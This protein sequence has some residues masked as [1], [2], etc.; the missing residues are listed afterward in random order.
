MELHKVSHC[1]NLLLVI[2]SNCLISYDND[3]NRP[4]TFRVPD[5]TDIEEISSEEDNGFEHARHVLHENNF[6]PR[7]WSTTGQIDLT[8]VDYE[9][10]KSGLPGIRDQDKLP[11]DSMYGML[12]RPGKEPE[13]L[14][15]DEVSHEPLIQKHPNVDVP[16]AYEDDGIHDSIG[17]SPLDESID[18]NDSEEE[19]LSERSE[20]AVSEA[21][22]DE[23]DDLD[24]ESSFFVR[25]EYVDNGD[26]EEY[27]D[28]GGEEQDGDFEEHDDFA[29]DFDAPLPFPNAGHG[30]LPG[31]LA[32]PS[33]ES[34]DG[35]QGANEEAP[36][37]TRCSSV[38]HAAF[39]RDVVGASLPQGQIDPR[40]IV[41][42]AANDVPQTAPIAQ[43]MSAHGTQDKDQELS[44]YQNTKGK[45][46]DYFQAREEN[47]RILGFPSSCNSEKAL[48]ALG[49]EKAAGQAEAQEEGTLPPLNK[50]SLDIGVD[51]SNDLVKS[52]A[53]FLNTPL[54]NDALPTTT[55][56][57]RSPILDE[58]SAYQ[59]EMSKKTK[60]AEVDSEKS[61][62]MSI[63]AIVEESSQDKTT[64]NKRKADEISQSSP[65]EEDAFQ[66]AEYGVPT[67]PCEI[68]EARNQGPFEPVQ[69]VT[70]LSQ[71]AT[72]TPSDHSRS[73]KR[74]RRAAEVFGYAAI[75]GIA[76]MSALIATA[77]AL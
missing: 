18:S 14:D 64:T 35:P 30:E 9:S 75:G 38:F 68:V 32:M 20:R 21:L 49:C 63:E 25:N 69:A 15:P 24:E 67:Q 70:L 11:H 2:T 22:L 48:E 74:L 29:E 37:S 76:V 13:T 72:S 31:V 34:D 19:C 7:P 47:R 52:G 23:P 60:E 54:T 44:S 46:V 73:P 45:K 55:V 12:L 57:A 3:H 6:R 43:G 62:N 8:A 42:S 33:Q 77:P 40:A 5:D 50:P 10:Q 71:S 28:D 56:R 39:L 61:G 27:D 59:F 1:T 36:D 66:T 26:E 16:G 51:L 17:Y 4:V 53:K 41:H 65:E 58:T